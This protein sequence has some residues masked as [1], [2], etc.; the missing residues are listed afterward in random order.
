MSK[1]VRRGI[2]AGSLD[3]AI[4]TPSG[5][6]N[7]AINSQVAGILLAKQKSAMKHTFRNART[8]QGCID[9]L[10]E[11]REEIILRMGMI[12]RKLNQL[13]GQDEAEALS[14]AW[15]TLINQLHESEPR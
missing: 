6:P 10:M 8:S 13:T 5:F 11:D 14:Q 3:T 1:R 9:P 7:L 2:H 15:R 12:L 4:A